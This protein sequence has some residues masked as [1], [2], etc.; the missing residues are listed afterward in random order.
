[1]R[2]TKDELP[3]LLE[4][5]PVVIRAIDWGGQRVLMGSLPAGLDATPLLAGLPDDKC[6][7][8]HWGYVL[9]GRIRV[10]YTDGTTETLQAGD[11]F[12]MPP[13][14]APVVEEDAEFI[15]FTPPKEYD[16]V[17]AVLKRNAA[18]AGG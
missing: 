16:E 8:P 5:G 1:M 10:T 17:L 4:N 13:G 14:H 12:Y 11:F 9:T 6:P 3:V 18:A 2:M 7:C 15:E